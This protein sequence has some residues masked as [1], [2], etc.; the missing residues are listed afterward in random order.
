VTNR[1]KRTADI[2]AKNKRTVMEHA[3]KKRRHNSRENYIEVRCM[4]LN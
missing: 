2:N 1:Q 4:Q 3:S